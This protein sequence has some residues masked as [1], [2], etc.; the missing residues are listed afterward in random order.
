MLPEDLDARVDW[1]T[2]CVGLS[3]RSVPMSLCLK[4]QELIGRVQQH[5]CLIAELTRATADAVGSRNENL[6]REL[7]RQVEA[8]IG[9]KERALGALRQHREEHGC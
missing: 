6:T 3:E 8:E 4:Q 7:D 5:L 2:T 9:A 1:H